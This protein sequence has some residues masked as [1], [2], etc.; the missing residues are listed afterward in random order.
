MI[1]DSIVFGTILQKQPR[2]YS[3][4]VAEPGVPDLV[5]PTQGWRSPCQSHRCL[6]H[7]QNLTRPPPPQGFPS[8]TSCSPAADLVTSTCQEIPSP[9]PL[10]PPMW[11]FQVSSHWSPHLHLSPSTLVSSPVTSH[12]RLL[13]HVSSQAFAH[14]GSLPDCRLPPSS[15]SHLLLSFRWAGTL[16]SQSDPSVKTVPPMPLNCL[17]PNLFPYCL[18]LQ[19]SASVY[20]SHQ[21]AREPLRGGHWV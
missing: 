6:K 21:E 18:S 17:Q 10:P 7:I 16:L 15:P 19:I 11:T 3:Q 4:E 5:T 9:E 13:R 14:A 20:L 1:P 8:R 12:E 2:S